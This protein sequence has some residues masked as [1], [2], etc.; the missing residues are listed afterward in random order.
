MARMAE[1]GE[2]E[3]FEDRWKVADA[4]ERAAARRE[5]ERLHPPGRLARALEW[6]RR[7]VW[8]G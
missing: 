6:L 3:R 2:H 1:P 8:S 7:R 5:Q 4:A